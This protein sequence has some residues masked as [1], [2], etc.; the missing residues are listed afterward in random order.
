LRPVVWQKVA[1]VSE[2]LAASIVRVMIEAA[3][4]SARLQ[5]ATTDKKVIFIVLPV[6]LYRCKTKSLTLI[7][8]H[9]LRV[10]E[11]KVLG[12]IFG[13]Q[14]DGVTEGCRNRIMR[15]SIICTLHQ[16]Y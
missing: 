3:S 16:N 15:S 1:D 10:F 2:V 8:E 12:R 7:E 11:N 4:T 13:P 14:R 5:G 6:V 9:R